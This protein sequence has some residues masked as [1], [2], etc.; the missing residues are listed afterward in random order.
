MLF[1]ITL[2]SYN[3]PNY[4][5]LL[6]AKLLYNLLWLSVWNA[7]FFRCNLKVTA[8]IFDKDSFYMCLSSLYIVWSVCL[9]LMLQKTQ[10]INLKS[11]FLHIF[12][13][14]SY[15]WQLNICFITH[16]V[17]LSIHD[18]LCCHPCYTI[19]KGTFKH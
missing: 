1:K 15:L 7:Y 9:S 10:I 12:I 6:V 2:I 3:W 11:I 17:H 16:F 19:I 14:F 18:S 13:T 4:I 5:L 8:K